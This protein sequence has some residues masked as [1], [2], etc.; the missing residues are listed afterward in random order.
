M[1]W[2]ILLYLWCGLLSIF[3]VLEVLPFDELGFSWT[4]VFMILIC[5]LWPIFCLQVIWELFRE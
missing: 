4:I 1:V 5:L 3:L 2:I